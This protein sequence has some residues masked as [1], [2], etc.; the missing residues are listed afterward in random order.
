VLQ[1]ILNRLHVP[2]DVAAPRPSTPLRAPLSRS[3]GAAAHAGPFNQN[4]DVPVFNA[5]A[6]SAYAP[7]A[8][9]E[10]RSVVVRATAGRAALAAGDV[11]SA[12]MP[13]DNLA[14]AVMALVLRQE[15]R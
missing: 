14:A 12:R 3:K 2:T 11:W 4:T 5:Y 9:P 8:S 7:A 6:W 1:W 15:L 13:I 10:V